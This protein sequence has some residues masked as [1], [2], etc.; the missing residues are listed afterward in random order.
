MNSVWLVETGEY[1]DYN[2]L[3]VYS[4]KEKARIAMKRYNME[5]KTYK[6]ARAR[7]CE[8]TCDPIWDKDSMYPDK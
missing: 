4:T 1:A 6:E 7:I 3:G 8:R 2:I 5:Y